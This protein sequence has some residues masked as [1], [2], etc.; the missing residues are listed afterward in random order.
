MRARG[1]TLVEILV[2]LAVLAFAMLAAVKAAGGYAGNQ[3]YLQ[4]RT[5]AHFVARNRLVEVQLEPTWPAIGRKQDEARQAGQDWRWQ[6][7]VSATPDKDIRRIEI[8][9]WA[10]DADIGESEPLARL[11]GFLERRE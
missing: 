11:S 2:A 5:L 4:D 1:F 9:V 10:A 7:E 8:R 3:A 6:T